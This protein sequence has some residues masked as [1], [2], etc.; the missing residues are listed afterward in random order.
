LEQWLLSSRG[1]STVL[2]SLLTI[3]PKMTHFM[4][5]IHLQNQFLFL[6]WNSHFQL[7][8]GN[9][10]DAIVLSYIVTPLLMP[11]QIFLTNQIVTCSPEQSFSRETPATI[12]KCVAKH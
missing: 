12:Y 7:K 11:H 5:S 3:F 9:L 6:N 4:D 8:I 1:L 10:L 2:A